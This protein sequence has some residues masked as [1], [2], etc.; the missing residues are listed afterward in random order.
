MTAEAGG[1]RNHIS[2]PEDLTA[3]APSAVTIPS[4]VIRSMRSV[5]DSVFGSATAG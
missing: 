1:V 4:C 2:F 5:M 3:S